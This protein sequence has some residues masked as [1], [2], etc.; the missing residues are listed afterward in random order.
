MISNVNSSLPSLGIQQSLGKSQEAQNRQIE[1]LSSG[2]RVNRAADDPAASA[3][4]SQFAAQISGSNQAARNLNDGISLAQTTDGAL[5]TVEDNTQRIRELTVQAGNSTL[6]SSDRDAIQNEVNSL[7]QSN[8]DTLRSAN[9]NGQSLFQGGSITFQSGPNAGGENQISAPI[10]IRA[11][12]ASNGGLNTANSGI[13]LSSPASAT[14]ALDSIDQ[15]ISRIAD[16]RASLGALNKRF[17]AGIASLQSNA[18]NLT[19]ARSRSADTDYAAATSRLAQEQIKAN[20]GNALLAQ[21][22]ASASKVLSLLR[23]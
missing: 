2:K 12:P 6:S 20:A 18:E 23:T 14:A 1:Q 15:D 10:G 17:E 3:I 5:S 8:N 11:A 9:Y 16:S 19:A 13:D 7:S 22:N 21:A 4:I